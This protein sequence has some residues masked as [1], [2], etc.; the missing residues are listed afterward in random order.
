MQVS[1][2]VGHDYDLLIRRAWQGGHCPGGL[3]IGHFRRVEVQREGNLL[4]GAEPVAQDEAL[5]LADSHLRDVPET[6]LRLE[7]AV[8]GNC[9]NVDDHGGPSSCARAFALNNP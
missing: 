5:V 4:A 8:A 3:D 6:A 9:H 2:R 1:V 7:L